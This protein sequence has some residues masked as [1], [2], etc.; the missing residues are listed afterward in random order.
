MNESFFPMNKYAYKILKITHQNGLNKGCTRSVVQI[1]L[2]K[3]LESSTIKRHLIE[4]WTIFGNKMVYLPSLNYKLLVD[5][6]PY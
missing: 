3:N 2:S 1:F 6:Y 4:V 5:I